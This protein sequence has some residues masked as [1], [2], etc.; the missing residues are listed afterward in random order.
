M[1]SE[2]NPKHFDISASFELEIQK[3]KRSSQQ[4]KHP[5]RPNS[6][7]KIYSFQTI[8]ALSV[9]QLLCKIGFCVFQF[10]CFYPNISFLEQM[11][12]SQELCLMAALLSRLPENYR[13]WEP[14]PELPGFQLCS[15]DAPGVLDATRSFKVYRF[16]DANREMDRA[17]APQAFGLLVPEWGSWGTTAGSR[18]HSAGAPQTDIAGGCPS[19]LPRLS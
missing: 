13:T 3:K 12:G 6:G 8:C 1:C 15:R 9:P 10:L 14:S 16:S 5:Y 19:A 7:N 11:Q 17:M 2:A 4:Q 18:E